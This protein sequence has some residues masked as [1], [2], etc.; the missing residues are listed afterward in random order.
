MHVPFPKQL[1]K[2]KKIGITN[3][4]GG[5]GKTS[6]SILLALLLRGKFSI[7]TNDIAKSLYD[8]DFGIDVFKIDRMKR[9]IPK[10]LLKKD[11]MI[12]DMGAMSSAIDFG[13]VD[14]IKNCDL[15]ILPTKTDRNSLLATLETYEMTRILAQDIRI[16]I[17]DFTQQKDYENAKEFLIENGYKGFIYPIKHTTLFRRLMED[18]R[19][20]F[21]N[22]HN[23]NGEYRLHQSLEKIKTV[24]E[25][26]S[27]YAL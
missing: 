24:L 4:K 8:T 16:I 23:N 12:Y 26:T 10:H 7:V 11:F 17:T 9:T 6:I 25:R 14:I 20:L 5:A 3:I 15:I 27:G 19:D 2:V 1:I 13:F 18:G 21:N 22:V